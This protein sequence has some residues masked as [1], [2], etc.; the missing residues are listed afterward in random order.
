[1]DL[2][3]QD[4]EY[5]LR[6]DLPGVSESDVKVEVQDGLLTVS[7]ARRSEHEESH[8]GYRRVER[9]S[10]SFSRSLRLPEGVDP[11]AIEASFD[12]GVLEVKI[13]KPQEPKS[14]RVAIK[15]GP[16]LEVVEGED[17]SEESAPDTTAEAA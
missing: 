5:V 6:A 9:A 17:S 16:K 12:N 1:M 4:G 2:V 10:G 8:E 3:E 15:V 11:Q 7:G 13:P 14:Q